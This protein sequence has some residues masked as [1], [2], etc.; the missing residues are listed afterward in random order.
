MNQKIDLETEYKIF[1]IIEETLKVIPKF[2][3][4]MTEKEDIRE[5][6][7]DFV[8]GYLHF[9]VTPILA[10]FYGRQNERCLGKILES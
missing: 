4:T 7:F 10:Y 1:E 5:D 3:L 2:N 6:I 8:N 9:E